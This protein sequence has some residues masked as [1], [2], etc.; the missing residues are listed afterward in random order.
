[1]LNFSSLNGYRREGGRGDTFFTSIHEN[2]YFAVLWKRLG[3]IAS[4]DLSAVR[5]TDNDRTENRR[6]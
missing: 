3:V 2:T 5:F 4:F 6:I 1:M